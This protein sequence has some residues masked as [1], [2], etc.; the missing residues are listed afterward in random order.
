MKRVHLHPKP[1]GEDHTIS[2]NQSVHVSFWSLTQQERERERALSLQLSQW[3]R[4][5]E[6]CHFGAVDGLNFVVFPKAYAVLHL[7]VQFLGSSTD[8]RPW[9]ESTRFINK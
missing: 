3:E 7:I 9:I 8:P 4:L 1:S 5:V 6:F 2:N